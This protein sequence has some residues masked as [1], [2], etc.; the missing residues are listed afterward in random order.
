[1]DKV[2]IQIK[3]ENY[4]Q[5]ELIQTEIEQLWIEFLKN[6]EWYDYFEA[7][8]HLIVLAKNPRTKIIH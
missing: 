1:M 5:G 3:I 7:Y 8:L 4:I 6:P 2:E